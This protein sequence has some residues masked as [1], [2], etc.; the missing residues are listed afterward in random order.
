[1]KWH[2]SVKYLLISLLLVS[3]FLLL[4][5]SKIHAESLEEKNVNFRWAFVAIVEMEHDQQLITITRSTVLKTGDRIKMFVEPQRC[6]VYFIH[7]SEE[8]EIELLFPYSLQQF[9]K[10][11]E[12][13]KKYFIPMGDEWFEM[14]EN[15][16]IET[17]YLIASS[18][19]LSNMEE[20]LA[21]HAQAE[22]A[23]REKLAKEILEVIQ[24][25]K[26]KYRSVIASAER[27]MSIGGSIRG[28][29]NNEQAGL[30]NIDLTANQI[31]AKNFY[32]RTFTID[33]R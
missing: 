15:A 11:H 13:T 18:S 9:D 1:M 19:R 4:F 28:V 29:T 23:D 12:T 8:D 7:R 6:F 16:G 2:G 10:E 21:K 33:H 30:I 5:K 22:G 24:N 14:D 27:P 25:L 32:S 20:F 26:K 31:S 3:S 17:F